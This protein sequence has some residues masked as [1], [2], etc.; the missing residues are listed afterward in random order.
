M[1]IHQYNS[2]QLSKPGK[3]KAV[4]DLPFFN[5]LKKF[6]KADHEGKQGIYNE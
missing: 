1:R 4:E 6:A 2:N 5:E 3:R